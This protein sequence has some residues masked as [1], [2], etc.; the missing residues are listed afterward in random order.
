MFDLPSLDY[1]Y[2]ALEP[3]I[4]KATMEIH[5]SKH[6][7]TYTN[8]LNDAVK[9]RP[10]LQ[11]MNIEDILKSLSVVP[12]EIRNKI[13]NNGGGYYNHNLY[14][15]FMSP[16][17]SAPS[18]GLLKALNSSYG[19]LDVFKEKF[20]NAALNHFGSG[21]AWLVLN[22]KSLE[23]LSTPNQ[24]NPISDGKTPVLGIDIWE[25]AYYLKYQN[26]RSDYI[27]AWWNIVNWEYVTALFE[28]F[29]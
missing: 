18:G 26:N 23:I 5:Y 2:S 3:Y 13:I 17:K 25:H 29:T 12:E 19:S 4:D 15:K 21:W 9:D 14:W 11:K 27:K 6:H 24:N 10:D 1:T 8:N 7:R 28:K 16:T 22:K 20:S